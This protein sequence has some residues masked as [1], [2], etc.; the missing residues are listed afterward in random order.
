[1]ADFQTCYKFMLPNED[2][3]PTYAVAPDPPPGAY[4]ISGINS[5]SF[6]TQYAAIAAIPQAERG[7][8]VMQFYLTTFWNQWLE[9][10]TSDAVAMRVFDASVNMGVKEAIV[11]LQQAVNSLSTTPLVV[12]GKIG[13]KTVAAANACVDTSLVSAFQHARVSYYE[14]IV[15]KNPA[16]AIYLKG[17]TARALK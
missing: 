12:D 15:A 4:A 11:L 16:D 1:M 3:V 5:F 13:P 17:W 2:A 8:A 9:Q 10:L 14:E 6:P 7:P